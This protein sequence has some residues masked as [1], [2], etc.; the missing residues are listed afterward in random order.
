M[1]VDNLIIEPGAIGTIKLGMSK[2][3]V[4]ACIQEYARK[5]QKEY[6]VRNYFKNVFRVEYD[7][8]ERVDFIEIP[9]SLKDE[10]NCLFYDIDVFN[11]KADDLVNHIDRISEYDRNHRELGYTYF[12]PELGLSL[13]RPIIFKEEYMEEDWF[14]EMSPENQEDEMKHLY[15]EAVSIAKRDSDQR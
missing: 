9:S 6:H 12:F 11:T 10:F 5:Y 7:V 1:T 14:K 4:E 15:F 2:D 8:N 13:W 3:E